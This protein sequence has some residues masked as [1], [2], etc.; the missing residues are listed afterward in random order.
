MFIPFDLLKVGKNKLVLFET[1]EVEIT[2]IHFSS[3]PIT[4]HPESID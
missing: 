1:E 3:E 2:E 4:I